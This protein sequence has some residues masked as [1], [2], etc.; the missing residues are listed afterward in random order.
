MAEKY[1]HVFLCAKAA[2]KLNVHVTGYYV[3]SISRSLIYT[4]EPLN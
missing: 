2:A 3:T 4:P 1:I